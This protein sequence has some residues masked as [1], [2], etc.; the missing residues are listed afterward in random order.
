MPPDLTVECDGVPPTCSPTAIDNCDDEVA[1]TFVGE[2]RIDGICDDTYTLKRT[3]RATD[4]CGNS[5]DAVRTIEVQDT[6]PP[7]FTLCPDD[8]SFQCADDVPTADPLDATATDNCG[9]VDISVSDTDNGGA[10][11]EG[12]PLIITRTWTATD[13]CDNEAE[14]VQIITVI[15]DTPPTITCPAPDE[16]I[17]DP[18][19][20]E[21]GHTDV[22]LTSATAEDN[23][24]A[25]EDITITQVPETF[26]IGTTTVTWIASDECGNAD[27]CEAQIVTVRMWVDA[28]KN[29]CPN[30]L[31]K[32]QGDVPF[33]IAGCDGFDVYDID[34]MSVRVHGVTPTKFGYDDDI[35]P[36]PAKEDSCDCEEDP[37][38]DGFDDL[39]F[40]VDQ[41]LLI[42]ALEESLGV[43]FEGGELVV[44]NVYAEANGEPYQGR[45]CMEVKA[46]GVAGS[47]PQSGADPNIPKV[48]A[49][50]Q[51]NPNPFT[52]TTV[53]RYQLPRAEHATLKVYDVTGRLVRT[54]INGRMKPGYYT[55]DWDGKDNKKN[56]VASGI[57]F[58]RFDAAEFSSRKKMTLLR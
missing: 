40:F 41:E 9:D 36:V 2:V 20:G 51:N 13:D 33:A 21:C 42:A 7:V 52:K 53:I 30:P 56:K 17:Y 11:C 8:E 31:N 18:E 46:A 44:V 1:I 58:L 6:T 5:T 55:A 3:F 12:D 22:V 19:P 38:G 49:L 47:G 32:G 4:D 16:L 24:T 27:T 26:P 34:T 28:H 29:S 54:L 57:Y 45:D 43:T 23:C 39:I 10:G 48:F 37:P 50:S 35:R 14:C 25:D 15:D